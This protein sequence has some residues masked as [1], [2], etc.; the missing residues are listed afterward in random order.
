M[1]LGDF[2]RHFG[3][4]TMPFARPV[5][6]AG[7]LHHKSFTES[8]ARVALAV[9]SRTPAAL[10]AEPGLGKSTLLATFA[11]GLDRGATRLV[12]TPLCACGPFGLI[13]QLAARYGIKP[14]RSAAQTAQ[15]MLDELGRSAKHEILVLDDA[16]RLPYESLDELRLLSNLDFDRVAPF[17]LL[18]VGQSALR[19][20]LDKPE[21]ASLRQRVAIRASLSPLSEAETIEYLDRRLRA[22]GAAATVFRPAAAQKLFERTCG[23]PRVINNL[24][25]AALLAAAGAGKKHVDLA[26]VES[27]VF[28]DESR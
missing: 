6:A 21:L 1:P 7:L 17:S 18:I 11:D 3:L 5:P 8:L 14:R 25:T 16:H 10:C 22:A 19:D 24:A 13:C 9:E 26:E 20:N 12:Y 2:L 27:A 23:V 15:V 4:T 28:D